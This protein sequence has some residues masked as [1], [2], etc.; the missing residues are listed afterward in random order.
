M[1]A[2]LMVTSIPVNNAETSGAIIESII[3]RIAERIFRTVTTEQRDANI[4]PKNEE[5]C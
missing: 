4:A 3:V 1:V 5:K 2:P